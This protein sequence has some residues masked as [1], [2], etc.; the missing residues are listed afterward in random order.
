MMSTVR[1]KKCIILYFEIIV[2]PLVDYNI[3]YFVLKIISA[4]RIFS[5]DYFHKV[6]A[7]YIYH[8]RYILKSMWHGNVSCKLFLKT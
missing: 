8:V 3:L 2:I 7:G 1:T 6:L 4:T 5:L